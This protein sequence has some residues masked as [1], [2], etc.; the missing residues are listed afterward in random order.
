ML[1]GHKSQG[2]DILAYF[3]IDMCGYR[4]PGDPIHTDIIAPTSAQPLVDF[5]T[6]VCALYLPG[7]IVGP[8]SLSGGDSDHTSF[9]NNGYMGIFPFE[10]SQN[11]SPYIHTSNDVIGLSV[12][13]L[14][15][16]MTFTQAAIANVASMA[17]YVAP[18]DNLIAVSGDEYI[19]LSW[20]PL[21]DVDYYNIYRDGILIDNTTDLFYLDEDVVNFTTYTYYVTAVFIGTGEETSP[22]NSVMIT[23]LP[24]MVFPFTDDFES[25]AYYWNLEGSWGLST[26]SYHSSSHSINE[27][28]SGDYANNLDINAN[29]YTFS[30]AYTSE[31]SVSFWGKY[32]LENNYDYMYFEI[33]AD[34]INWTMLETF[35]GTQNTWVQ[36]SYSLNSYLGENSVSLRF[37]FYSDYSVV[38]DG[39][40]IDDFNIDKT[41]D[42]NITTFMEGPF[43]GINMNT[44]VISLSSFPLTQPYYVSP[45]NY[46][47]GESVVS[48]P[49]TNIVDWV[50]IEIRDAIDPASSGFGSVVERTAAFI[51]ND[52]SIVDLDGFSTMEFHQQ[53]VQNMFV[54]VRH[55]NHLDVI[56]SASPANQEVCIISILH[57]QKTRHII[58]DRLI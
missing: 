1:P 4:H 15:M 41:T 49:N 23:L 42:L 48:V 6:D 44:D 34:G 21:L 47:G 58:L 22:S 17:N 12:N 43:N 38:R 39:M 55:R 26:S 46:P 40:Y 28:P 8:G 33:S 54:V 25:G 29:L 7:F 18:P 31:A 2:M 27:S 57:H 13:S 53:I 50:L 20:D 30:L 10:D 3:N 9:N 45:W 24:R 37:R 56:S 14:E 35:N 19:Q 52:G 11:Y 16:A 51:L 32:D 5:Y 36:Y